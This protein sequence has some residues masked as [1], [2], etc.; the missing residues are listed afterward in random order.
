[1]RLNKGR[2]FNILL[3]FLASEALRAFLNYIAMFRRFI[4]IEKRKA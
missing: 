1:M 4:E 3:N 2:G